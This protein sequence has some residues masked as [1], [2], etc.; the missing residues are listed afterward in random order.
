MVLFPPWLYFDGYTSNQASAGYHLLFNPPPVTAYEEM[1]GIPGDDVLTT[2]FVRVYLNKVRLT[3]QVLI[4]VFLTVGLLLRQREP[5]SVTSG[6]FIGLGLCAI[7]L[8]ILMLF[9]K[10]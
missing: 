5:G 4:V 7:G 10:H 3:M 6:C 2:R 8:L 1:F 9:F